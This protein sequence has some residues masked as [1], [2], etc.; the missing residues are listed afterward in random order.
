MALIGK[1]REKSWLLVAIVGLAMFAFIAGDLISTIQNSFGNTQVDIGIGTINGE[2]VNDKEYESL[3]NNALYQAYQSK[4]QQNNGQPVQLDENDESNAANQAWNA[5]LANHLM[6][7]EFEK[8]GLVVDE[9]ELE[10]IL[11]GQDDFDPC[12]F[13][14]NFKDSVT[15]EFS[16]TQLRQYLDNL[17]MSSDP[18]AFEQYTNTLR[19]IREN[20]VEEKYNVLLASGFHATTLE[21]KDEYLSKKEVKNVSYVY[22]NFSAVPQD[23]VAEVNEEEI[24]NYFEQHKHERKYQQKPFRK[25]NYFSIPVAPSSEDTA[26]ISNLLLKLKDKLLASEN[27]SLFVIQYSDVKEFSGLISHPKGTMAAQQSEFGYYGPELEKDLENATVGEVFGPYPS[28]Q[29]LAISKLHAWGEEPYATVRHILLSAKD[30][31]TFNAAQKKADSIVSVIKR[32]NNFEEM[33]SL[34]SED[35][36]S[37]NSGGK[38]ES[39]G[40]GAMVPTFNDFSFEKPIGALG[41]VKTS[42]GIHII[43]VLDRKVERRPILATVAKQIAVTKSSLDF[44]A[45]EATSYIYELDDLMQGKSIDE[46]TQL[47]DTFA[48]DKGYV[49]RSLTLNVDNPKAYGF[50]SIA[51]GRILKLAFEGDAKEGNLSGSAIKDNDKVVVAFLAKVNDEKEPTFESAEARMKGEVQKEKQAQFLIDQMV[52][53]ENLQELASKIGAKYHSEGLTFNA[54]NTAV[55]R[56]P[57]LLGTAFSG[58]TDGETTV[59]VKGLNGAFVLRVDN[60]TSAEETSDYS[61]EQEQLSNQYSSSLVQKYRNALIQSA[62][63]IDNRK[64]R[65]L[66][67]R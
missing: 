29:Y 62:E 39:F 2:V 28:G 52:G 24:K 54:N 32:K 65:G 37:K 7:I 14:D 1:I 47:F 38:Y 33:V 56:E 10:N 48:V 12:F 27:D 57:F 58:L 20:R 41:T 11:Y 50:G 8:I 51:E 36:G 43:E 49:V 64:L 17:E 21:A 16:P 30:D 19:V 44:I 5:L 31:A 46:K 3:K 13:S 26:S 18:K 66:S 4:V 42:Y 35:P 60:T 55:G 40:Q 25:I 15:G 23:A 59:P 34:F 22:Q 6:K 45:G 67:I 61:T 53:Q 9:I 63:V